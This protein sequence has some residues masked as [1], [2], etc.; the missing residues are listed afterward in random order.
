MSNEQEQATAAYNF[1]PLGPKVVPA[2]FVR[3]QEESG[4]DWQGL[5]KEDQQEAFAAYVREQGCNSGWIDLDIEA[6]GFSP[7]RRPQWGLWA[8]FGGRGYPDPRPPI[9]ARL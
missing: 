5:D 4:A 3:G 2:P 8:F 1:V 9:R 7:P 6:H